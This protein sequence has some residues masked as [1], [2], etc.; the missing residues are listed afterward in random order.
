MVAP[1]NGLEEEAEAALCG[2]A[3]ADDADSPRNTLSEVTPN[4]S[5]GCDVGTS[6]RR[7]GDESAI[8]LFESDASSLGDRGG[9]CGEGGTSLMGEDESETASC[10]PLSDL[11]LRSLD[12]RRMR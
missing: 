4:G 1:K 7:L 2:L 8:A 9:G 10:S 11:S 3:D 5:E 6:G 12:E